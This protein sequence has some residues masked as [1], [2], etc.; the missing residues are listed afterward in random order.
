[1][2][3]RRETLPRDQYLAEFY[4]ASPK[5]R[6]PSPKKFGA[7]NMQNLARFYTTSDFDCECLGNKTSKIGKTCDR[8]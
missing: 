8:E 6:G 3:D 2:A 7:K 1:V 4:D 5:I